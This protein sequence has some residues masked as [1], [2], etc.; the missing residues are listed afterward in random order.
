M[1]EGRDYLRELAVAQRALDA[2]AQHLERLQSALSIRAE[3]L[4]PSKNV[5]QDDDV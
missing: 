3:L 4:D 2:R 5:K 1:N